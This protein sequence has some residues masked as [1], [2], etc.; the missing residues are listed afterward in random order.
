MENDSEKNEI[1]DDSN[2]DSS[3]LEE[4]S[5]GYIF[6]GENLTPE[7]NFPWEVIDKSGNV[8]ERCSTKNPV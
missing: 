6:N 8:L 2:I 3:N 4:V 1:T 7:K 5:G